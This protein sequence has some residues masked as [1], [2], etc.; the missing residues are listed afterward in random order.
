LP[1]ASI[2]RTHSACAAAVEGIAT[3]SS[4]PATNNGHADRREEIAA[5]RPPV[6]I[7][8]KNMIEGLKFADRELPGIGSDD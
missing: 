2:R 7:G 8:E 4:Q 6:R 3:A 1:F 5:P